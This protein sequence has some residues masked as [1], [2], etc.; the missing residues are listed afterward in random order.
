[1]ISRLASLLAVA[2][3]VAAC[4]PATTVTGKAGGNAIL[5]Y[6]AASLKRPMTAAKAA[7]E[8]ANP[9]TTVTVSTDS[10]SALEAK[11]EQG[12]PGDVFL[13]ADTTNPQKLVDKRLASGA[14]VPFAANV[15]TIIVPTANAAAV[16]TPADLARAG[17]KVIAAGDKVPITTYSQ[18]LVANLAK[19]QGYPTDFA[20]RY[21]ANVVS[22]EDNVAAVVTK[23]ELGEGDAGIVYVTDARS[24]S[25]VSTID[26]PPEA[27]VRATY[28]GVAIASAP[29]EAGGAAFLAWLVGAAGQATLASF[30]FLPP[31]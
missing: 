14:V 23:I 30:G 11:I 17:V 10:S 22:K 2:A 5:V 8:A 20:A 28:G 27:N 31:H 6:A 21:A 9:G 15:L 12:A 3:L 19:A 25:K 29:N 16:R 26:V 1:M 4:S 13:S 7:Y 24:S 18:Q